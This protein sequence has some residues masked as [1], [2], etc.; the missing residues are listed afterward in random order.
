[1]KLLD[2]LFTTDRTRQIFSD[3]SP[4]Q[5]MLDFEAALARAL[6]EA[7]VAPKGSADSVASQCRAELYALDRIATA[8]AQAGNL[9][10]PLVKELTSL[11][12]KSDEAA[13]GFVHLG[14]TSQ[15]VIDT[16]LVLQLRDA[17]DDTESSLRQLSSLLEALATEHKGTLLAGRTWLQ[18]AAPITL[19]LKFAGWLDAIE[20]HRERL[21]Q[22]RARVEVLQFGGA[23]GTL[24]ALG[25]DGSRVA[26]AL[27]RELKLAL[28]EISWHGQRDRFAELAT[29]YGLLAGTLGKIARDISL[30]A[31]TEIAELSEPSAAGRGGSSTLPQKRNPVGCSVVLSAAI[32]VPALVSTM[33]SAMVQEHERGLGGWQAEWETLPEICMLTGGALAHL[34]QVISGLEVDEEAMAR[35]LGATKGLSMAEAVSTALAKKIGKLRAHQIVEQ[36]AHTSMDSAKSFRDVLA[37]DGEISR[38]LSMADIDRLLDPG[39][40]IGEAATLIDRVVSASKKPTR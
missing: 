3:A 31:Q 23:V 15:D 16:G 36:A 34:T 25:A 10:I 1:M 9:A 24:A 5:R 2:P 6:E 20:R 33:L 38:H 40:Y 19:G 13:A 29:T 4:L 30:M 8:A 37:A 39:Q 22:T 21:A 11:V 32:R 27:A 17:L 26:E 14:A 7:G 28:P 18:Q 12:A 35:N